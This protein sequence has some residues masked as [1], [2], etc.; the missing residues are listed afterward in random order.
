MFGT[1]TTLVFSEEFPKFDVEKR[2]VDARSNGMPT[3]WVPFSDNHGCLY[4][5]LPDGRIKVF[6]PQFSGEEE[7]P[8][9][10]TWIRDVWIRETLEDES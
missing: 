1:F 9:L 5:M 8:N 4:C 2:T 6:D 10:E 7:W 3:S